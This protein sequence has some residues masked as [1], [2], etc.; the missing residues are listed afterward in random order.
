MSYV[1]RWFGH[2]DLLIVAP[3]F[4]VVDRKTSVLQQ[5]VMTS[6]NQQLWLIFGRS[7]TEQDLSW[8]SY[9]VD[10][11][12]HIGQIQ[13]DAILSFMGLIEG[14]QSSSQ[15]PAPA[16]GRAQNQISAQSLLEEESHSIRAVNTAILD[17]YD[18]G[19]S[20]IHFENNPDGLIIKC[21]VDGVLVET[22]AM[23]ERTAAEQV[24]S[25]LKVLAELDIAERR[26]PQDGRLSI[27]I[28]G[29]DIDL[30]ISIM[31]GLHG[32]DAVL[33]IL[34]KQSLTKG[35]EPLSL[36]LL[37]FD[38]ATMMAIRA[39]AR[40]PYGMLL[41]TGPTGSGKTTSLY[42]LLNERYT[43]QEKIITIEDPVEYQLKGA[44]QI[45]VNERKGL[46]FARGLRSIL[47]HDP[48]IILV[49]EIRDR[50]TADI[51]V[52]A[53][54]TGHLVYTSVHANHS[55]DVIGRFRHMEIDLFGFVSSLNGI[56]AQRLIRLNCS[57]C[58][59][60]AP[61]NEA[62]IQFSGISPDQI[63]R[64]RF[65]AGKGCDACQGTGYRGRQAIAEVLVVDET[66]RE[67]LIEQKP[68]SRIRDYLKEKGMIFLRQQ[69]LAVV[70]EGRST[71]QEVNRVT[72]V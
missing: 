26:V 43:G 18:K 21:R 71:L 47:R 69:A 72:F 46:T 68:I 70:A 4:S 13:P 52:Q 45:P 32:E 10:Q 17:A 59:I 3:D 61:P 49:G 27:H 30:R 2:A 40:Q 6:I 24:V 58:S 35:D 53:A 33:R 64:Y 25:R 16:S 67:M 20:D 15:L 62:T 5:C 34:D 28:Q 37:G 66:V 50:E 41:V 23:H 29:R 48:D 54:L 12:L 38:V 56:V 65:Q 8:I 7:P 9:L 19:A 22:G 57:S 44:L 31:P 42:A 63:G 14:Q 11:P 51:A 39:M 55:L 60:P 1:T 36:T